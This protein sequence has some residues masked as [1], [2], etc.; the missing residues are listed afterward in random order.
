[1]TSPVTGGNETD[2]A[3]FLSPTIGGQSTVYSF[4]VK[5]THPDNVPP[6]SIQVIIDPGATQLARDMTRVDSNAFSAGTIYQYQT[7]PPELTPGT[8]KFIFKSADQIN[9]V[10]KYQSGTTPY[11]GPSVN[12]PPVLAQGTVYIQNTTPTFPVNNVLNPA[13]SG[14]VLTKFIF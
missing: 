7:V 11:T 1:L 10:T 12:N 4:K 13:V 6:A 14:N 8:H 5:Y 9:T 2:P 3:T